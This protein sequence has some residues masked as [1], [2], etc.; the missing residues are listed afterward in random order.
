MDEFWG[1]VCVAIVLI[2]GLF[3]YNY[4]LRIYNRFYFDKEKVEW[5]ETEANPVE[6]FNQMFSP[7]DGVKTQQQLH[8]SHS[9]KVVESPH[10]P[11]SAGPSETASVS[12]FTSGGIANKGESSPT[13]IDGPA[14]MEGYLS[15]KNSKRFTIDNW[16]RRYF[17]L[18]ANTLFYYK[19]KRSYQLSP[20][21]PINRRPIDLEGYSLVPGPPQPPFA[22]SLVPEADDIRKAWKFRC[23]T[24]A[25]F[26]HWIEIFTKALQ[27]CNKEGEER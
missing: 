8:Q 16:D 14:M 25:E 19:E 10:L 9:P 3:T 6:E 22:L 13:P 26:N 20:A 2:G 7:A 18:M 15:M 4:S 21:E 24:L 5:S 17:V 12:K 27:E 23:D 1:Y 11:P